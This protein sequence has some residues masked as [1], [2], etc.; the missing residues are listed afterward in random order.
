MAG[1]SAALA[2]APAQDRPNREALCYRDSMARRKRRAAWSEDEY[3]LS[4]HLIRGEVE[5]AIKSNYAYLTIN[6]LSVEKPSVLK[7]FNKFPEFWTLNSF[8]LQ[9]TF[10]IVF[11]RIFDD[12]ADSHSIQKLVDATVANPGF[13]SKKALRQRKRESASIRGPDPAWLV[14]YVRDAWEPVTADLAPLKTAL[15]PHHAKFKAI[16]QPI[17]HQYFAHKSIQGAAGISALFGKTLIGDVAE[18]LRFLHTLLWAIT[19]MAWNAKPPDLTDFRDYDGYVKQLN[20]KT[21]QFIRH[22]P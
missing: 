12:R 11:G 22:L 7:K 21:E 1:Y 8:S 17:R 10:F 6:N 19:E 16:Y 9:T 13:F 5:A 18:I 2:P 14:D 3:W 15:A 4:F 20:A